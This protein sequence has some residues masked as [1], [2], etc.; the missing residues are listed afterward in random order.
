MNR[1]WYEGTERPSDL[2]ERA[3]IIALAELLAESRAKHASG[4]KDIG[5][6]RTLA[7]PFGDVDDLD[8]AHARQIAESLTWRHS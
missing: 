3:L 2:D 1:M 5:D 6:W 4:Q 7:A 8:Y